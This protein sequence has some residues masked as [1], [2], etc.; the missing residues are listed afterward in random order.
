M[1][2]AQ[3]HVDVLEEIISNDNNIDDDETADAWMLPPLPDPI[4]IAPD[5]QPIKTEPETDV[6]ENET[7]TT[8]LDK[9]LRELYAQNKHLFLHERDNVEQP[10]DIKPVLDDLS[11]I[12][13]PRKDDVRSEAEIHHILYTTVLD[14]SYGYVYFARAWSDAPPLRRVLAEVDATVSR[15]VPTAV[16]LSSDGQLT[17]QKSPPLGTKQLPRQRSLLNT[18]ELP[19]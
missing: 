11:N 12:A 2:S 17:R 8:S 3:Q 14:H 16:I 6:F 9:Q 5:H 19:D 15:H 4:V 1:T 18:D 10:C 13:Q 7:E